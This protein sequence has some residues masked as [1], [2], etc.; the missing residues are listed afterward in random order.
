MCR[1]CCARLLAEGPR[2]RRRL[3]AALPAGGSRVRERAG[4]ARL[5]EPVRGLRPCVAPCVCAP[6]QHG[7]AGLGFWRGG[8]RVGADQRGPCRTPGETLQG[9]GLVQY[10]RAC[11]APGNLLAPQHLAVPSVIVGAECLPRVCAPRRVPPRHDVPVCKSWCAWCARIVALPASQ[12]PEHCPPLKLSLPYAH[13]TAQ[14]A[15]C[16]NAQHR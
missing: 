16:S 5:S 13:N 15:H 14:A 11:G 6:V 12:W 2:P 3:C 9:R 8:G 7:P 4:R 10:H 1:D